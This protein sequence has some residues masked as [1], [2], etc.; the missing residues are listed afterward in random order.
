[1]S[2]SNVSS[3]SSS[4][5]AISSEPSCMESE[6]D[7][8]FA[9]KE[10]AALGDVLSGMYS[11][12]NPAQLNDFIGA[13]HDTLNLNAMNVKNELG[14]TRFKL[15]I[16]AIG[17]MADSIKKGTLETDDELLKE[18]IISFVDKINLPPTHAV[19]EKTKKYGYWSYIGEKVASVVSSALGIGSAALITLGHVIRLDGHS[20]KLSL[21]CVFGNI[22]NTAA[23]IVKLAGSVF[24]AGF[25][26]AKPKNLD[27]Y[28][29]RFT[30]VVAITPWTVGFVGQDRVRNTVGLIT[31]AYL[32]A[33]TTGTLVK[34]ARYTLP[35]PTVEDA[36]SS[37]PSEN[38]F[39]NTVYA[40]AQSREYDPPE[41]LFEGNLV[42]DHKT[43]RVAAGAPQG[44]ESFP[45]EGSFGR[46]VSV[47]SE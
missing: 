31:R 5:S 20:A 36:Q 18:K 22:F 44:G 43:G 42:I 45:R 9:A 30:R 28:W 2:T 26:V 3:S 7:K 25:F 24:G 4:A 21:T 19:G 38:A 1:M 34:A 41:R 10:L 33:M 40:T 35:N 17:K 16:Q 15:V 39:F 23:Q 14:D 47:G 46:S 13:V 8:E 11:S 12:K 32:N 37:L 6:M 29:K 27:G